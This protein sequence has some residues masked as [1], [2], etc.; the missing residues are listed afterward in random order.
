MC[1]YHTLETS[2]S[3]LNSHVKKQQQQRQQKPRLGSKNR[4]T[5][6]GA[7]FDL[8][9]SSL[10]VFLFPVYYSERCDGRWRVEWS[11]SKLRLSR[12]WIASAKCQRLMIPVN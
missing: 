1:H 6:P 3:H 11:G 2:Y 9:F 12:L 10:S 8:I 4:R 7:F 5:A